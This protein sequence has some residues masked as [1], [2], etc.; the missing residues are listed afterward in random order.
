MNDGR[1]TKRFFAALCALLLSLGAVAALGL[2]GLD[3]VKRSDDRVFSDN[4]LTAQATNRVVTDVARAERA[5]LEITATSDARVAETRRARL[6]QIVV[7][8]VNADIA[9]LVKIHV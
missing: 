8:Q 1:A 6:L 7:P 9:T 4:F 3:T 2:H 5:A